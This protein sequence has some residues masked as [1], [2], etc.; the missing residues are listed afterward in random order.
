[1]SVNKFLN[2][3]Y[4]NIFKL[5]KPIIVY[6]MSQNTKFTNH[7]SKHTQRNNKY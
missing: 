2:L 4:F 5:L 6:F 1:M 3:Y 7:K